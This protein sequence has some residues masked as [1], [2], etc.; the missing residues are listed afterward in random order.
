MA[1]EWFYTKDGEQLGPVSSK[2]PKQLAASGELLPSD[3]VWKEGAPDWKP[4]SIIKGLFAE[5]QTAP[6]PVPA[7]SSEATPA[8][9]AL[10]E[11]ARGL[12][13]AVTA[14]AKEL[15]DKATAAAKDLGDK[16][17]EA[18]KANQSDQQ[19]KPD[20]GSPANPLIATLQ[21]KKRL[22]I[23]CFVGLFVFSVGTS[24]LLMLTGGF[25]SIGSSSSGTSK[26]V[27]EKGKLSSFFDVPPPV[28]RA[29]RDG[30]DV[31]ELTMVGPLFEKERKEQDDW[32]FYLI[33]EDEKLV[34][35]VTKHQPSSKSEAD[36]FGLD[37]GEAYWD[38][39]KG[40]FI[41]WKL[42]RKAKDKMSL[43][44]TMRSEGDIFV[45][46]TT[47]NISIT[48]NTTVG[49]GYWTGT[50]TDRTKYRGRV[51]YMDDSYE[52]RYGRGGVIPVRLK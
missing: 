18:T 5:G 30:K 2:Q 49:E 1:T 4:A 22:I 38:L 40:E 12:F 28:T 43:S 42:D 32:N 41:D 19:R 3:L 37:A 7:K 25:S 23:F 29:V 31:L 21:A 48:M 9:P 17:A 15:G 45:N 10:G 6:P 27:A 8:A 20:E 52:E 51:G 26:K 44:T 33:F 50:V 34:G 46:T 35:F 14:K 39:V 13:S 11:A 36:L 24:L 16:A 47:F